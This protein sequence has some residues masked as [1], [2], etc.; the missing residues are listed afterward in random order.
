MRARLVCVYDNVVLPV[1]PSHIPVDGVLVELAKL[2]VDGEDV[3]VVVLLKV[4]HE[5]LNRVITSM[6][7]PL[8]LK[9]FLHLQNT[10]HIG[11]VDFSQRCYGTF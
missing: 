4:L 1:V 8:T 2:P 5:Q 3:H 11:L 9:D 10:K 7:T 6:K